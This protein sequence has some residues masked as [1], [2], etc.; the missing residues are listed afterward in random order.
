VRTGQSF[1]GVVEIVEGL[2]AG[3]KIVVRGNEALQNGQRVRI[4]DAGAR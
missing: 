3:E 1:A 2:E 4:I